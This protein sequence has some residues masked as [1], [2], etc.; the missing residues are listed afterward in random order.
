MR[1]VTAKASNLQACEIPN[2]WTSLETRPVADT[3]RRLGTPSTERVKVVLNAPKTRLIFC[4]LKYQFLSIAVVLQ[5]S[6]VFSPAA[7]RIKFSPDSP[8]GRFQSF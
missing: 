8:L 3:E 7:D 6:V 1:P 2:S 4:R 5:A